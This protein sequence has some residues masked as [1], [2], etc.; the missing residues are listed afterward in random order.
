MNKKFVAI[1]SAALITVGSIGGVAFATNMNENNV[2]DNKLEVMESQVNLSNIKEEDSN[3]NN[4][5]N[6][7]ADENYNKNSA[8][9]P[10]R[11]IYQD[12]IKIMRENGYKDAARYMQTENYD[13]M[14]DYMN[15]MSQE[16]YDEM[17]E[18]MN[19]YG[20]GYMG[21]MMETIGSEGMTQM[22]NS[23]GYMH[24]DNYGMMGGY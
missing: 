12:M 13:A 21:Q 1:L 4:I 15:N 3:M 5:L 8:N 7:N 10:Y 20:Y 9:N 19:D 17:I 23:M 6:N 14:T 18:I 2:D 16:E 11:D 22:Y 24:G